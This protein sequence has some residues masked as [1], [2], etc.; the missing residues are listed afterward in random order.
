MTTFIPFAFAAS[1][2]FDR[3]PLQNLRVPGGRRPSI[4]GMFVRGN[5]LA[6]ARRGGAAVK[7]ITAQVDVFVPQ[8]PEVVFEY[9]ADLRHEPGYH[10]QVHHIRKTTGGPLARGT[11]F[12]GLHSGLGAVSWTLVEYEAPRHL[13]IEGQ[14][15]SGTYRWVSD[16]EPAAEGAGTT[17]HGSM[18][19]RPGAALRLF[20]P[21]LRPLLAFN[22]RRSFGKFAEVLARPPG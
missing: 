16:F 21:L 12:E 17:M 22:A 6:S 11:R 9:F 15:G 2:Y 13:A 20:S 8:A 4:F 5:A 1:A 3:N 7:P 14:V 18:E 10:R 19:W